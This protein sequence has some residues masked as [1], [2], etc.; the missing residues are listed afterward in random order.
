MMWSDPETLTR[1]L[2]EIFRMQTVAYGGVLVSNVLSMSSTTLHLMEA[3]F[4]LIGAT[5]T[6]VRDPSRW[7]VMMVAVLLM[8]ATRGSALV[9]V[10]LEMDW[11]VA[12]MTALQLLVVAVQGV[13]A[14]RLWELNSAARVRAASFYLNVSIANK[15]EAM[16]WAA[17]QKLGKV[18]GAM[19]GRVANR[20]VSET[21]FAAKCARAIERDIPAKLASE[22]LQGACRLVFQRGSYVVLRVTVQDVGVRHSMSEV[23]GDPG[24]PPV[25]AAALTLAAQAVSATDSDS[26][27]GIADGPSSAQRARGWGR[28]SWRSVGRHWPRGGRARPQEAARL[29]RAVP[30]ATG[31]SGLVNRLPPM[32]R[33]VVGH[34][35]RLHL[36]EG[37]MKNLPARMAEEMKRKSGMDINVHGI[38]EARQAAFLFSRLAEIDGDGEDDLDEHGPA[39][40]AEDEDDMEEHPSPPT[41]A[42][43]RRSSWRP[44][45]VAGR[46]RE[47]LRHR[48]ILRRAPASSEAVGADSGAAVE[49]ELSP[50]TA[51]PDRGGAAITE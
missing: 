21:R 34:L 15:G 47:R 26:D 49:D 28:S 16:E 3:T 13:G 8:L 42:A 7:S 19:A 39:S 23:P 25:R 41:E 1:T 24:H 48:T 12:P 33:Q 40:A 10:V 32:L 17:K 22:G 36:A 4:A 30:A 29:P 20:V 50:G 5:H 27:C 9:D 6:S 14:I 45:S 11:R 46:M 18:V 37:I 38:P 31:L 51:D 44:G 43:A 35:L 2:H